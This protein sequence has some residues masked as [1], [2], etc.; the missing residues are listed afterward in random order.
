MTWYKAHLKQS[1]SST[2]FYQ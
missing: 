1:K 2:L